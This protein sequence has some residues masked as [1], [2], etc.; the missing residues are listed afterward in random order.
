MIKKNDNAGEGNGR[1]HTWVGERW[2][3]KW[4][5][6]HTGGGKGITT[7]FLKDILTLSM[8]RTQEGPHLW[9]SNS[10]YENVSHGQIWCTTCMHAQNSHW[11]FSPSFF[12]SFLNTENLDVECLIRLNW[13]NKLWYITQEDTATKHDAGE[14]TRTMAQKREPQRTRIQV[15]SPFSYVSNLRGKGRFLNKRSLVNWEKTWTN[16]SKE[17]KRLTFN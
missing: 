16:I 15:W 6:S 2:G 13:S 7:F 1:S 12:L 10:T 9:S 8:K 11:G 4:L 14:N 5:L 17:Y 3:G